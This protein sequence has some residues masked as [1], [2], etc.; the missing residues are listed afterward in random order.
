MT[1]KNFLSNFDATCI[2]FDEYTNTYCVCL[3]TISFNV[4]NNIITLFVDEYTTQNDI[5]YIT[6][7]ANGNFTINIENC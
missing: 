3:E 7:L 4:D 6:K 2:N 1:T 5:D